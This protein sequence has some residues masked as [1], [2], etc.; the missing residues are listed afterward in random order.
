MDF[1]AAAFLAAL[2][3]GTGAAG[4]VP[5]VDREPAPS[6]P[7]VPAARSLVP[8]GDSDQGRDR[9]ERR[10]RLLLGGSLVATDAGPDASPPFPGWILR[11]D[12]AGRLGWEPPDLPEERRT[13]ARTD[14]V[15]LPLFPER[16]RGPRPGIDPCWWCGGSDW[17]RSKCG[18]VLCARCSPPAFPELVAD[19]SLPSLPPLPGRDPE[20]DRFSDCVLSSAV[21]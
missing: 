14:L 18:V 17:W 9:G 8:P 19:S 4:A 2:V 11:P 20:T 5:A 13:W 10:K 16:P 1:D 3:G 15:E 21:R 6:P 7:I 12:R